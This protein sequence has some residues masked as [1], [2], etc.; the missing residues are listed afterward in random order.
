MYIFC[1]PDCDELKMKMY[2]C[3]LVVGGGMMFNGINT[4]LHNRLQV[5]IPIMYRSEQFEII[6]RPK[7]N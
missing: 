3:V 4:W 2:S 6:T 1:F 7:V 5:Q